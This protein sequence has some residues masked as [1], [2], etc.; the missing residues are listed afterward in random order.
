MQYMH[1]NAEKLSTINVEMSVNIHTQSEIRHLSTK[2]IEK[3]I[4]RK[5]EP[6][7]I[8]LWMDQGFF[9]SPMH[10]DLRIASAFCKVC[11]PKKFQGL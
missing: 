3:V 9:R 2:L 1:I 6:V 11:F 7:D 4:H 10:F 8:F 5:R